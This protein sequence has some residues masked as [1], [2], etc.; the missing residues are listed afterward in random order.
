MTVPFQQLGD[1]QVGRL[2]YQIIGK[3]G[4]IFNP[5]N[6]RYLSP[7]QAQK[8]GIAVP[9]SL[10]LVG[11]AAGLSGLN[12]MASMGALAQNSALLNEVRDISGKIDQVRG[13][14]MAV[15]HQLNSIQ[16][17]LK[18]IDVKVTETNLRQVLDWVS[19]QCFYSN[20]IDLDKLKRLQSDV[21]TFIGA[22]PAF[23][24]GSPS[25]F[26]LSS[27]V[28]DRLL[29]LH[30]LLFGV[31]KAVALRHNAQSGGDPS[32]VL[33]VHAIHDYSPEHSSGYNVMPWFLRLADSNFYGLEDDI[34]SIIPSSVLQGG[35]AKV[36]ASE[37]VWNYRQ[38]FF[39]ETSETDPVSVNFKE[40]L[41]P[42]CDKQTNFKKFAEL[43]KWWE[44]TWLLGTDMGLLYRVHKEL[45]ALG[46]Y[47]SEFSHWARA[48]TL[49]LKQKQLD[50]YCQW[51]V[52]QF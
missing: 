43:V 11:L 25:Y 48:N 17:T 49:P 22:V 50:I 2:V 28:Q 42:Y 38:R 46:D 24:Y 39:Q 14:Q 34:C 16:K 36:A 35:G 51:D 31:R 27:D 18:Q 6:I 29:Q 3:N 1:G 4:P 13:M 45:K 21:E 12:F 41:E 47:R 15:G 44:K 32:R 30:R 33:S 5:S 9:R 7:Q 20:M 10:N 26:R 23:G 52:K 8:A 19:Q 40:A 37:T